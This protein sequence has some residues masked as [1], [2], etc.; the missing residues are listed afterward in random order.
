MKLSYVL[1]VLGLPWVQGGL[2][3]NDASK[4]VFGPIGGQVFATISTSEA[5]DYCSMKS[6]QGKKYCSD[7]AAWY[8]V[9]F[10]CDQDPRIEIGSSIDGCKLSILSLDALDFGLWKVEAKSFGAVATSQI[11]VNLPV[12]M[13]IMMENAWGIMKVSKGTTV[14]F[15]CEIEVKAKVD[16]DFLPPKLTW[17]VGDE[18]KAVSKDYRREGLSFFNSFSFAP[19]TSDSEKEV[20]CSIPNEPSDLS[21]SV[22][23]EVTHFEE[24]EKDATDPAVVLEANQLGEIVKIIKVFPKPTAEDITWHFDTPKGLKI[25]KPE[26]SFRRLSASKIKD[27]GSDQYQVEFSIAKVLP[28]DDGK[29]LNL[30]VQVGPF[31][32]AIVIPLK[33]QLPG[34]DRPP[35]IAPS[36]QAS[37]PDATARPPAGLDPPES[38]PADSTDY[39]QIDDTPEGNTEGAVEA[40]EVQQASGSMNLIIIVAIIALLIL[41]CVIYYCLKWRRNKN[42]K[43]KAD[44]CL[45]ESLPLNLSG[46]PFKDNPEFKADTVVQFSSPPTSKVEIVD[47]KELEKLPKVENPKTVVVDDNTHEAIQALTNRLK[48][49]HLDLPV[50]DED[51][52]MTSRTPVGSRENSFEKDSPPI[53]SL[54]GAG[55]YRQDAQYPDTPTS[56]I[57]ARSMEALTDP[58][59][60]QNP[61]TSLSPK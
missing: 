23:L 5:P 14:K 46:P 36:T 35:F 31:K 33:V 50:D 58:Q 17:K 10:N 52:Y 28:I 11:I 26:E 24:T 37:R 34:T 49:A 44:G 19:T 32:H 42:K 53:Q 1:T 29:N 41:L 22:A 16:Q 8:M 7:E 3:F 38:P 61:N 4:S 12:D 15:T 43:E 47:E 25:L 21:D 56:T 6:P 20:S 57:S 59:G 48:L 45:A 39:E 18:V 2:T 60:N 40:P 13:Q 54:G 9:D 55:L 27:L 30:D 51:E